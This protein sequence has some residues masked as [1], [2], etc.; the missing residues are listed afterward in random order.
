MAIVTSEPAPR[1]FRFA[2]L[3]DHT[4]FVECFFFEDP[5]RITVEV[6][7]AR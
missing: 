5:E 3:R 6:L 1:A 4:A 7:A 2:D